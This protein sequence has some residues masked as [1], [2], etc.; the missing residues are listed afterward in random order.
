MRQYRENGTQRSQGGK[1]S[2]EAQDLGHP[3]ADRFTW[4]LHGNYAKNTANKRSLL[5]N[6]ELSGYPAIAA[7]GSWPPSPN[8]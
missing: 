3:L 2:W 4:N 5:Q 1:L 7:S 8:S 6:D